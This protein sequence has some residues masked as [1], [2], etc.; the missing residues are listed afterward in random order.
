MYILKTVGIF[1]FLFI[2]AA[3]TGQDRHFSQSYANPLYL[4]PG[5]T[6]VFQG[7]YR[8]N[9]SYRDQWRGALENPFATFTL[10]ADLNFDIT[11]R[12]GFFG[13]DKIG[14]GI[15]FFT[16]KMEGFDFNTNYINIFGAF[17]KSLD[18]N[19]KQFLTLGFQGGI[20][21]KNIN[22]GNLTFQDQ[23]VDGS[24]FI[25]GTDEIINT[26]NF[27]FGDY[28]IGLNYSIRPTDD[29][30]VIG[31]IAVHHMFKPNN[32]FYQDFDDDALTENT[33]LLD[34]K[35]TFYGMLEAPLNENSAILPRLI[36]LSQGQ[37]FETNA[38]TNLKFFINEDRTNAFYVGGW[39]RLTNQLDG[40]GMESVTLFTGISFGEFLMGFSYDSNV[41]SIASNFNQ[42][43]TFELTLTLIG[44]YSNEGIFCPTF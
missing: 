35:F 29:F 4:S 41:S 19:T 42:R 36:I 37:H 28:A 3:S 43:G 38:G 30:G 14:A 26:N 7:S 18:P 44:S 16:D 39:G 13:N 12:G 31:G 10:S 9:L 25:Q 17:H 23:F 32:S 1:C 15:Q 20:T 33:I 21:Q 22:F 27:A 24:G 8:A 6:G 40:I 2:S 5:L 34:R 11:R